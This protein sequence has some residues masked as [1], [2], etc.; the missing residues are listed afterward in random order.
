MI[1]VFGSSYE[2]DGF[3]MVPSIALEPRYY[4]NFEKRETKGKR[5]HHNV[6]NVEAVE[7]ISFIP[8]WGIRRNIGQHFNYQVGVGE[9]YYIDAYDSGLAM[10]IHLRIG[11]TL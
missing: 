9:G 2:E 7:T 3:A 4:Y 8:K 1:P 5:I 11:Y 10:D 6:A